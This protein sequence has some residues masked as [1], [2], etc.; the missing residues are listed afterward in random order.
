MHS[1]NNSGGEG[2][3]KVK[4]KIEVRNEVTNAIALNR[5]VTSVSD[6]IGRIGSQA[7]ALL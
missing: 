3:S 7:N 6:R 4:R 5:V 1:L 2:D